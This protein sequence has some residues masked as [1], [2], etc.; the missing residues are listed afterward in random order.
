MVDLPEANLLLHGRERGAEQSL[1]GQGIRG[2]MAG[3]Q[4]EHLQQLH[5]E[6]WRGGS[7]PQDR[8]GEPGLS[9]SPTALAF[10]LLPKGRCL[11]GAAAHTLPLGRCFS[12]PLHFPFL[13]LLISAPTAGHYFK[14]R[15]VAASLGHLPITGTQHWTLSAS[16][17]G[18]SWLK[19]HGR[20]GRQ[21][22]LR[23]EAGHLKEAQKHRGKEGQG[24]QSPCQ[25][26][27][28]GQSLPTGPAP[29]SPALPSGLTR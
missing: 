27:P 5:E 25:D 16:R 4:Q 10:C 24:G 12:H 1:T 3:L 26:T 21:K 17:R 19:H 11:Q 28:Q 14:I 29:N 7:A 2:E 23:E 9:C 8:A 22:D 15:H 6:G 13:S 18:Q 20:K